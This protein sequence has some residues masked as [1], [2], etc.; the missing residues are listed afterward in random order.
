MTDT[1]LHLGGVVFLAT[2]ALFIEILIVGALANIWLFLIT[3]SIS[4]CEFDFHFFPDNLV[5]LLS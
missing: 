2:T 3:Y 5:L 1:D 4:P